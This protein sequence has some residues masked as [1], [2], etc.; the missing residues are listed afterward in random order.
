MP[1][2]HPAGRGLTYAA[3][4]GHD[5]YPDLHPLP[6]GFCMTWGEVYAPV[7]TIDATPARFVEGQVS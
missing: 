3:Q 5:K 6:V 4:P 7:A 1:R 2:S